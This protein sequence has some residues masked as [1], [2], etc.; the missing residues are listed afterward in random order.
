MFA[1]IGKIIRGKLNGTTKFTNVNGTDKVFPVI[2]PQ[3]T[4]YPCTTY[5][6]TGLSNFLTKG[7]SLDSCDL[8][9][10]ICC[11]ADNY[12]VTYYQAREAVEAL[13][14]YS[15]IVQEEGIS[16]KIKFRFVDLDDDYFK[17]P[18]KFYKNINFNCLIIK[19]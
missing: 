17:T 6:I 7:S 5:E 19:N 16:Y 9:L 1:S 10:R 14:L 11:F 12:Q 18:E 2:I 15:V 13:D 8:S 3:G 4:T